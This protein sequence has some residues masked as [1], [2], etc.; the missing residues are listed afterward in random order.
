M[1][2]KKVKLDQDTLFEVQ[3]RLKLLRDEIG[4]NAK[5]YHAVGEVSNMLSTTL[6]Q[7]LEDDTPEPTMD[8]YI[9]D[10]VAEALATHLHLTK[11]EFTASLTRSIDSRLDERGKTS[12]EDLPF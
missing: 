5:F 6:L 2:E 11:D 9:S 1:T 12:P 7:P 8:R 4:V 3:K 10:A